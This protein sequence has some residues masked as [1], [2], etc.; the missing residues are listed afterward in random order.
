M[1]IKGGVKKMSKFKN[2]AVF[3]VST[4]LLS[5]SLNAK[6]VLDFVPII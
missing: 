2:L 5:S 6:Y 3:M 1:N 4:L